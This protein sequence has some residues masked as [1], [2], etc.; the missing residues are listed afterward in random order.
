MNAE[1]RLAELMDSATRA[2][3]PP[4]E[5]MLE[6]GERR[7]RRRRRI[8]R[9]ALAGSTAA[10]VLLAAGGAALAE[11]ATERY[12]VGGHSASTRTA[13]AETSP[14]SPVSP[15]SAPASTDAAVSPATAL[16]QR[17]VPL[18]A[19]VAAGILKQSVGATW[20]FGSYDP[21]ST[22]TLTFTA[23]DGLGLFQ[24]SVTVS[25]TAAMAAMTA[26]GVDPIDCSLQG[27]LIKGGGP[28]PANA[29]PVGCNVAVFSNGDRVMQEVLNANAYGVYQYRV[30][31]DRTDGVAVEL[32]VSNGSLSSPAAKFTRT[33]PP[34]TLSVWTVFATNHAW[35]PRVPTSLTDGA[36][37]SAGP[38]Q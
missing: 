25:T 18:N 20:K 37:P 28:R 36:I 6:E 31:A 32:A 34:L 1:D 33:D 23:D 2:L 30:V 5:A 10:V 19:A 11:R 22:G 7:G 38:T 12:D 27:A 9:T 24:I 35:Q 29:I 3:T 4:L 8:R 13:S 14:T 16:P 15:S 17:L 21:T 26:K